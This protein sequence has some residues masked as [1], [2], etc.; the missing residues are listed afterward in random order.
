MLAIPNNTSCYKY[1]FV[2]IAVCLFI[3]TFSSN[4]HGDN[5]VKFSVNMLNLDDNE[6]IDVSKFSKSNYIQPGTYNMDWQVNQLK[7]LEQ[8]FTIYQDEKNT[9]NTV[10]CIPE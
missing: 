8:K 2:T 7:I 1:K 9:D 10:L 5:D 4:I 3:G 6:N